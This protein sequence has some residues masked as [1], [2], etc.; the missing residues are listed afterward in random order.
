MSTEEKLR[1]GAALVQCVTSIS[2]KKAAQAA[3]ASAAAAP[4]S[5][6]SSSQ[7]AREHA[8]ALGRGPAGDDA[9]PQSPLSPLLASS[10]GTVRG[11][12]DDDDDS[13]ILI[14]WS[15]ASA[16]RASR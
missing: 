15:S 14:S 2:A 3:A 16:N 4:A 8:A 13:P 5:S 1:H 6:S 11:G 9:L 12:D 10:S 7:A